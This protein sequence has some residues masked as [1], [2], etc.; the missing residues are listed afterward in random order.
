MKK[1]L[2]VKT[3]PQMLLTLSIL[4]WIITSLFNTIDNMI[5]GDINESPWLN[6]SLISVGLLSFYIIG[7]KIMKKIGTKNV[8]KPIETVE[9]PGCS[10]CGKNKSKK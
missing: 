1:E 10:S 9:K 2:I 7:N 4:I 6:Y 3:I 8:N 5:Y